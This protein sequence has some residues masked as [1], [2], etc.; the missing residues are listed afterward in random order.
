MR[1]RL[2]LPADNKKE[3]T[4]NMNKGESVRRKMSSAKDEWQ[5]TAFT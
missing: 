1:K 3:P 2:S 5:K 4:K